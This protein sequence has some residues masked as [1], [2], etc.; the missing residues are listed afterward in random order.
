[1][2]RAAGGEHV[3]CFQL[4]QVLYPS[5][6]CVWVCEQVTKWTESPLFLKLDPQVAPTV[7]ELPVKI[8]EVDPRSQFID[9]PFKIDATP[10]ESVTIAHVSK[11]TNTGDDAAAKRTF[12]VS[13]LRERARGLVTD[14]LPLS[15]WCWFGFGCS[16]NALHGSARRGAHAE[17]ARSHCL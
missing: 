8:Y 17:R 6:V 13:V 1:M 2:A 10:A 15:L 3:D 9:L 14:R 4:T 12:S 11:N 5:R 16:A 7:K